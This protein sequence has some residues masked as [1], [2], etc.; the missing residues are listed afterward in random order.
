MKSRCCAQ[1][2]LTSLDREN[3][4]L[5]FP[6]ILCWA[7]GRAG[8]VS[9]YIPGVLRRSTNGH[10]VTHKPRSTNV[11]PSRS[12]RRS[13]SPQRSRTIDQ[14]GQMRKFSYDERYTPVYP[15]KHPIWVKHGIYTGISALMHDLRCLSFW[16]FAPERR[17]GADLWLF[18]RVFA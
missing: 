9:P 15:P 10:C 17:G 1:T 12:S 2:V 7:R 4:V 11:S 6:S 3:L 5:W 8:L 16:F 14:S 13:A 18:V